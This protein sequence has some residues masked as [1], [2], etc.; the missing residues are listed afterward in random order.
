MPTA[1]KR[2]TKNRDNIGKGLLRSLPYILLICASLFVIYRIVV[3][4]SFKVDCSHV[5]QEMLSNDNGVISDIF[6]FESAGKI[7]NIEILIYSNDKQNMLKLAIPTGIYVSEE[8]VDEFP[9]SSLESVGEFLSYGSGKEYT[10]QYMSD[11]LGIKFDSYVWLEDSNESIDEF[12][13]DLSVWSILFDF[14]YSEELQGHIYSNLPI[15]NLITQI[16]YISSVMGEYEYE[17]LDISLCCLKEVVIS[18]EDKR[19][20][21]DKS[22]FD[23]EFGKYMDDLVSRDVEKER[24]NIEVYNASDVSGLASKYARKI[25]HT[26]CRILRFDNAPNMYESTVIFIPE[27]LGYEHSLGLVRDVMG[28]DVELRYERPQFIT[29]GDIVV[30]LGKDLSE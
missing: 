18:G 11:L 3:L 9:L 29:T 24:V 17:E 12:R 10:V 6:I 22:A 13:K 16:N 23:S 5:P 4:V 15:I 14:E 7:S 21:F 26:G 30:V 8:G 28:E 25:R 27:L 20:D 2:K 19:Q 1:K